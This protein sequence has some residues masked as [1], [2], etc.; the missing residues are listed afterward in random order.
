MAKAPAPAPKVE[1]TLNAA[2][3]LGTPRP[4]KQAESGWFTFACCAARGPDLVSVE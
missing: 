2:A 3:T 1:E 4:A